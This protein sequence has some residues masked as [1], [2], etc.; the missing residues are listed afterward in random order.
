MSFRKIA[1]ALLLVIGLVI[2]G[3]AHTQAASI[4]EAADGDLS[5]LV[6]KAGGSLGSV[7]GFA[8]SYKQMNA[9]RRILQ[10]AYIGGGGLV[11]FAAGIFGL[12][13]GDRRNS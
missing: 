11:L 13:F 4:P 6:R 7:P 1:S 3:L 8:E 2:V 5:E 10:N 12:I 9:N